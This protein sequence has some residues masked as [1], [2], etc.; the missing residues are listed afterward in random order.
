MWP[1]LVNPPFLLAGRIA[2]IVSAEEF[3]KAPI[4]GRNGAC[5]S[6]ICVELTQVTD[7]GVGFAME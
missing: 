7:F 5:D 4:G 2:E 3:K 6:P 1:P